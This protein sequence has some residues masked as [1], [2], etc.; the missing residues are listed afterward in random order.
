MIVVNL[1]YSQDC[2][3]YPCLF[4]DTWSISVAYLA[5]IIYPILKLFHSIEV[6]MFYIAVYQFESDIDPC[7]FE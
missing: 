5:L 7:L 4:I 3:N 1:F 2:Y 6:S